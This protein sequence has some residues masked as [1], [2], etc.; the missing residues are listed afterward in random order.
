MI[1]FPKFSLKRIPYAPLL[2]FFFYLTPFELFSEFVPKF[3]GDLELRAAKDSLYRF[4]FNQSEG[5]GFIIFDYNKNPQNYESFTHL[6]VQLKNIS[7]GDLDVRLS[8]TS[9]SKKSDRYTKGRFLLEPHEEDE[10]RVLLIRNYFNDSHPWTQAFDRI[11]GLPGGHFSNWR[12]LDTDSMKNVQLNISWKG[13]RAGIDGVLLKGPYGSG[14]YRTSEMSPKDLPRPLIDQMGQLVIGDWEGRAN[15][16][17]ELPNDGVRDFARFANH[18]TIDVFNQYGGWKNGP[19]FE[20]T[21][22]FYTK[23]I[24]DKWW[25]VDPEGYLFWSLGVTGVGGGAVTK[26]SGREHFFPDALDKNY[27]R[28][29]NFAFNQKT[30]RGY[31]FLLNNLYLKYGSD[32]ENTNRD[33][34]LGRMR[35]WGLN[36]I[37]A[38]SVDSVL[39]NKQVPYTLIVHPKL[40]GLGRLDKL[41]DPFSHEFRESLRAKLIELADLYKGDPWNLGVFIDNE[42]KWGKGIQVAIEVL[43]LELKVPAKLAM[44]EFYR[45]RYGSIKKLNKAWGSSFKSF[46]AIEAQPYKTAK[47][48]YR[49]DLIAYCDYFADTYFAYCSKLM[50]MY[51]PGH[52]YLGCRFHGGIYN[53]NN[54]SVQ[55]AASRHVD[56][57][58]YNIYKTSIHDVV[59]HQEIDRPI[60]IGEFHFGTGSHGVWGYGLVACDTLEDQAELYEIYVKE[61]IEHPN[62]IGAH[63]FKWSDHPTTGRYDGENYRIGFINIVDRDYKPLTKAIRNTAAQMYPAR[64]IAD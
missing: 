55:K 1:Y 40:Q 44:V 2:A 8:A 24:K 15:D 61:T 47:K 56:V 11:R 14:D 32:W 25:F 28:M 5:K 7:Q 13:V 50:K 45:K 52:L 37:G 39:G 16:I 33:V 9:E 57:M 38:W 21:G 64:Y 17:K 54:V 29:E 48:S 31:D 36:T 3:S 6:A 42:L 41:P 58:S 23:K 10:M 34:T 43:K 51:L 60:V 19:K 22:H 35:A 30:F 26:I 20:A 46:E 63:W 27:I 18:T 62:F 49:E 4:V 12:Y 59:T 53:A